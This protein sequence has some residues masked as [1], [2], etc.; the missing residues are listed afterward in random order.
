MTT[1][2]GFDLGRHLGCAVWCDGEG[3][4]RATVVTVD[5]PCEDVDFAP[6]L[7]EEAAKWL[8]DLRAEDTVL[9]YEPAIP[10]LERIRGYNVLRDIRREIQKRWR[11]RD[12]WR[13]E[14][15][16]ATSVKLAFAGYGRAS[17]AQMVK[18]AERRFPQFVVPCK[19]RTATRATNVTLSQHV[20][21]AIAIAEFAGIRYRIA[22]VVVASRSD[23]A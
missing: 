21:D 4:T 2:V 16:A 20:A 22:D 8:G 13:H 14:T 1:V 18:A 10:K 12:G 17:K 3:I 5:L 9:A 15:V 11:E 23:V 19:G 7:V 6:M